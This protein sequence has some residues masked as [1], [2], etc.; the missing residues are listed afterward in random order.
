MSFIFNK[1]AVKNIYDFTN[2]FLIYILIGTI[3][4]I[5]IDNFKYKFVE[6]IQG[7]KATVEKAVEKTTTTTSK[8]LS[9]RNGILGKNDFSYA[10]KAIQS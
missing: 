3:L 2:I 4:Y 7:S 9:K 10:N 6:G 1:K 5:F 8:T